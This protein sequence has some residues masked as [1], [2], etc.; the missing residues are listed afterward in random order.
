MGIPENSTVT[1]DDASECDAGD[2][3]FPPISQMC[4]ST[5]SMWRTATE[6]S[7]GT[8]SPVSDSSSWKRGYSAPASRV[9]TNRSSVGGDR[10]T[11]AH[12]HRARG[13]F[14]GSIPSS[15]TMRLTAKQGSDQVDE[16]HVLTSVEVF[17]A[18]G[19]HRVHVCRR[20]RGPPRRWGGRCVPFRAGPRT[21]PHVREPGDAQS[22]RTKPWS[23]LGTESARETSSVV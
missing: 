16:A 19:G 9:S 22:P 14:S 10:L 12:L 1:W 21:G 18:E 15:A 20:C 6:I 3:Q 4:V 8:A 2:N 17:R 23:Q 5:L 7:S 11:D 13:V